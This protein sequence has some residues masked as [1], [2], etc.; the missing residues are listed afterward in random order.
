MVHQAYNVIF[1][2][3]CD[4][5]GNIFVSARGTKQHIRVI[6]PIALKTTKTLCSFGHFEC[7]RVK[8]SAVDD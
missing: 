7:N 1:P 6:N 2:K 8:G 3:I 5:H 4:K